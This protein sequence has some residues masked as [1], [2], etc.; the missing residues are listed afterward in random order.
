MN[1]RWHAA[2]P[3]P[4]N[5]TMD[6]RIAWHLKHA[7]HCGCRNIPLGIHSELAR[8]GI[9]A[10]AISSQLRP[11]RLAPGCTGGKD[12]NRCSRQIPEYQI[13]RGRFSRL[14]LAR[15]SSGVSPR[16]SRK[17]RVNASCEPW[18]APSATDSVSGAS[19]T[20]SRAAWLRCLPRKT[21]EHR[22]V[23]HFAKHA[24]HRSATDRLPRRHCRV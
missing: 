7:V 1:R 3:M 5:P 18:P 13:L 9:F 24:R 11:Q 12:R 20:S 4:S 23:G 15:T 14:R 10:T 19:S 21:Y 6:D 2:N 22:M 17:A 8:R 16:K